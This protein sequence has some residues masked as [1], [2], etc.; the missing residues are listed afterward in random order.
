MINLDSLE[1]LKD[2]IIHNTTN[3]KYYAVY[4]KSETPFVYAD[5]KPLGI[6]NGFI[7]F[8]ADGYLVK[9]TLDQ[10][11]I[12]RI[13]MDVEAGTFR[14]GFDHMYLYKGN[15]LYSIT[16]N[17]IVNWVIEFDDEIHDVVVDALD[18]IYIIFENLRLI[19]KYNSNGIYIGFYNE[20]ETSGRLCKLYK[21]FVDNGGGNLYVAVSEFWDGK[22]ISYID[23]YDSRKF[24]LIERMKL[25]EETD[26]VSPYSSYFS[27]NDIYINGDYMYI[28]AEN[29]LEKRNIKMRSLWRYEFGFNQLTG[30]IDRLHKVLFDD[31]K[32]NQRIYFCEDLSS[33]NGYTFGK[34]TPNG[35]LLWKVETPEDVEKSEFNLLIYDSEIFMCS[36]RDIA[37]NGNYIL[38]LDNGSVLMESRNGEVV[39]ILDNNYDLIYSPENYIGMY[40][41]AS[42]IKEGVPKTIDYL[43]SHDTGI[44]V[45]R[46]EEDVDESFLLLTEENK[47]YTNSENY[48][49]AKMIGFKKP[50][51]IPEYTFLET[52]HGNRLISI[53][54]S[55]IETMY[56]YDPDSVYQQLV[57]P[58]KVVIS[59]TDIED[60]KIKD[61]FYILADYH[62]FMQHIITKNKELTI[63]TKKME[64]AIARKVKYI[65]RYYIRRMVDIDII[66]E[67]L[68]QLGLL[69]TILPRYVE[70]LKYY[71]ETNIA[72]V[73][74]WNVPRLYDMKI[75]KV[76]GYRYNGQSYPLRI[77]HMQ[78]FVCKNLPYNNKRRRKSI[79]IEPMID[80]IQTG[81]LTPFILF[82]DGKAIK[83]SD[84]V[85]I[86]DWSYS[87]LAISNCDNITENIKT[88]IL[89]K[90][91]LYG[92]DN[93]IQNIIEGNLY[94]NSNGELT[95]NINEIA[96]RFEFIDNLLSKY[97]PIVDNGYIHLDYL[98][99]KFV[100]TNTNIIAFK[101]GKLFS[102]LRF[103]LDYDGVNV[104]KYTDDP[105]G[106]SFK[107]YYY[108]DSNESKGMIYDVP[109]QEE[110]KSQIEEKIESNNKSLSDIFKTPFDFR[111]YKEKTY[112]RNVSEAI[113][114]IVRYNLNLLSDFYKE[115][116]PIEIISYT[117]VELLRRL[118]LPDY[119]L[120]LSR[121]KTSS[122]SDFVIVFKNNKLYEHM[123]G[124]EYTNRVIAIPI[125]DISPE[126]KIEII[127]FTNVNNNSFDFVVNGKDEC[128][129]LSKNI[130]HDNFELYGNNLSGTE[131]YTEY[132]P[133]C[134]VQYK[135][136]VADYRN[137]FDD[138]NNYI[139]TEIELKDPYYYG[140][141]LQIANKR[142]FHY[143]FKHVYEMEVFT[144]KLEPKFRHALNKNQYLIFLN[145]KRLMSSEWNLHIPSAL[146]PDITPYIDFNGRLLT[147]GE[148]VDIIYIPNAF[149]E[150]PLEDCNYI[151]NSSGDI[152]MKD[153]IL[154]TSNLEYPYPFDSDFFYMFING[155]K[156]HRVEMTNITQ[157][158]VRVNVENIKE[159]IQNATMIRFFNPDDTLNALYSYGDLWTKSVDSLS[160]EEYKLLFNRIK[161]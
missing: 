11:E 80:L 160:D 147:V 120:R 35:N 75:H 46:D 60:Y 38:S 121:A 13:Y 112:S 82:M 111:F 65:H 58:D 151:T 54:N 139:G 130:R 100:T 128:N 1:I 97:E 109:N 124:I 87:Y 31:D 70:K 62:K 71:T 103:Y 44:V 149:T 30:E 33:S 95:D 141:K 27:Y 55:Y 96:I 57:G 36:K 78:L 158:R 138:N 40:L 104:Y 26:N 8:Y 89:P 137:K 9:N 106:I 101:D 129:Y 153:I 50:G 136:D 88:I 7:Y 150:T 64:F 51:Y 145:Q 41:L 90:K 39:R 127:K 48:E 73:Q 131:N 79:F 132:S 94:F 47:D 72:D 3:D 116:M 117:G 68:E 148:I 114:Y 144:I 69:E 154:D 43:L 63:I 45:G 146:E 108:L 159:P 4:E 155:K 52:L 84:I 49:Y 16:E 98:P 18:N 110:I 107:S 76:F 21:L 156:V 92:E 10:V 81:E 61:F 157:N 125:K 25:C 105:A 29:Y 28:Y 99:D 83:W 115:N 12:G 126:D 133:T 59:P 134:T 86:R 23:H 56:P 142:Q 102:D 2:K 14:E 85:V 20:S 6:L 161:K 119:V 5:F 19:R 152:I 24:T 32:Y 91:V 135:V 15:M 143:M 140:K 37:S 22:A 118:S 122:P 42:K 17:F 113:S 123:N 34:L 66:V 67:Y 74:T 53:N 93:N 77:D